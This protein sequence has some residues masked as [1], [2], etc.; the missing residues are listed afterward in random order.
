[1]PRLTAF[2]RAQQRAAYAMHGKDLTELI[3]GTVVK[4]GVIHESQIRHSVSRV[5]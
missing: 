1:M 5:C 3:A 4:N 2:V